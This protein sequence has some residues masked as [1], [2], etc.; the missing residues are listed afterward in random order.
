M[1]KG[2]VQAEKAAQFKGFLEAHWRPLQHG[3]LWKMRVEKA[4]FYN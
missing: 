3:L 4:V 1:N 2:R